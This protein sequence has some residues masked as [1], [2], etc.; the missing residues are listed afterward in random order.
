M[1]VPW[2]EETPALTQALT[3]VAKQPGKHTQAVTRH[4]HSQLRCTNNS[5][6]A[7]PKIKLITL[8]L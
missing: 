6:K 8:G 5:Y 3:A 4:F 7:T 1:H 2:E